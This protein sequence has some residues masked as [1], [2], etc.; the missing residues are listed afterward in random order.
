VKEDDVDDDVAQAVAVHRWGVIAEAA[1]A[2]LTPA[3]RGVVVRQ[4]AARAHLHPDGTERR[5]SRGTIDRW[6]RSWRAGGL[7][8][9]RPAER[10][11]VGTVRAHPELFA[12]A[13]ALR[14]ELPSR[15]AAQIASILWH[16]HRIRVAERTVRAQLRRAG[17]HREALAAEPKVF[18]RYEADAPTTGGSPTCWSAPGCRGP[19]STPRCGPGCSWSSMITPG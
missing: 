8:A 3:E 9:L 4:I 7:D 2:R 6:L 11:D 15:S 12:E 19:G 18:G 13:A 14:L 5:Y 1:N 10:A 17:L 16:R